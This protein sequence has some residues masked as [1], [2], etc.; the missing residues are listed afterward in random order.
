MKGSS[1]VEKQVKDTYGKLARLYESTKDT[2]G[3]L[4]R[5]YK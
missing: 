1:V 3:K 5:L 2:Y 4:A